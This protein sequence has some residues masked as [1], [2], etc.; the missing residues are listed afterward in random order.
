MVY[1]KRGSANDSI[2]CWSFFANAQKGAILFTIFL[3]AASIVLAAHSA[4]VITDYSP[5]YETTSGNFSLTVSNGIL[6]SNSINNVSAALNGFSLL[7]TIA[8]VGWQPNSSGN[9]LSFLTSDHKISNWGSQTFGFQ[10]KAGNVDQNTTV[11]W[12]V[13][14]VDTAG[15][16]DVDTLQILILN[17]D[18]API[19]SGIIPQN[20]SFIKKGTSSQQFSLIAVDPETGV[21]SVAGKYGLCSNLSVS[22]S[23]T[24]TNDSYM[25]TSDLSSYDDSTVLCYEYDAQNNGGATAVI[26]GMFTIDG[27]PPVV[28]LIYPDNGIYMN[29]NSLFSYSATDNLAP[30]ISCAVS[31]DNSEFDS[32]II[33]NGETANASVDNLSE[34]QHS[35]NASCTDLAGNKGVSETRSFTLDRTAPLINVTSPGS[36]AVNKAGIPV[37]VTVTDNYGVASIWYEFQDTRYDNVTSQFS[38][39]TDNATDGEN[40]VSIHATDVAGNEAVLNYVM[41]VDKKAPTIDLTSPEDNATVDVHVPFV[42]TVTDNYDPLLDC[43]VIVDGVFWS[44]LSAE[45][46]NV[47]RETV[48]IPPGAKSIMVQCTDDA[49]NSGQ[50]EARMVNIQDMSG[51]DIIINDVQDVVR[52]E[53]A[54][55]IANITD[56]S[57]IDDSS[58]SALL[59]LPNGSS[60]P[61]S[62]SKSGDIYTGSYPTTADSELGEYNLEIDAKDTIGN[63]N[64]ASEKFN[65]IHSYSVTLQV[66]SPVYE[67]DQVT[68]S[69]TAARDDGNP[70]AGNKIDVA[71]PS[72]NATLDLVNNSFSTAFSAP[73][74]GSYPIKAWILIGN[75]EFNATKNLQVDARS[76]GGG[77]HHSSGGSSGSGGHVTVAMP[78]SGDNAGLLTCDCSED[79]DCID[80]KCV[81]KPKQVVVETEKEP[82]ATPVEPVVSGN[83]AGNVTV[84]DNSGAGIGKAS[85]FFN[86]S[87]VSWSTLLWIILGIIVIAGAIKMLSGN[88][89]GN[90]GFNFS[91]MERY[92]KQRKRNS[93]E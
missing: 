28:T 29:N 36:G 37:N 20:G 27:V 51:P 64:N 6:S 15:A 76:S 35:W 30:T 62:L 46:G 66:T 91:E 77:G 33:N 92:I 50:T 84:A 69:G 44:N 63:G 9:V 24:K 49:D 56:I 87:N 47:T 21:A 74:Q 19:I 5:I 68:V 59:T 38:V 60:E 85:G 88:S 1:I 57:G 82:S 86:L 53:T 26:N 14:S 8:L 80:G 54:V 10:L 83:N 25:T 2:I 52:G 31:A 23:F 45:N 39:N 41:I 4:S 17:D 72:G 7:S 55:F 34:G 70:V 78:P 67:N 79:Q 13:T 90:S 93:R 32:V 3:L 65:V 81:S 43:S 89:G 16:A 61:V 48:I 75:R 22:L 40:V 73:S 12:P 71:L 18:T 11:D 42:M 58:V